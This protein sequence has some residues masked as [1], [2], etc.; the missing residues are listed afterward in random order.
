MVGAASTETVAGAG[1]EVGESLCNTFF[2]MAYGGRT[3]LQR[4]TLKLDRGHRYGLVGANGAGK[5]TLLRNLA[6][7]KLDGLRADLRVISVQHATDNSVTKMK[8]DM[9]VAA[10]GGAEEEGGD[11]SEGTGGGEVD[12]YEMETVIEH[13]SRTLLDDHGIR[14]VN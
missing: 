1:G 3:L 7:R 8:A 4:T 10:A 14:L 2:S 6:A 13:L 11:Q 9:A 5:S 12:P